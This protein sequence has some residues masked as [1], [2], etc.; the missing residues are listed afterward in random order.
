MSSFPSRS[1]LFYF[2]SC[3]VSH[4]YALAARASMCMKEAV[5]SWTVRSQGFFLKECEAIEE[6]E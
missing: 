4:E 5:E 2:T 3:A 6:M 1:M